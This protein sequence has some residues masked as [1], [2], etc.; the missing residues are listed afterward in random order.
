MFN[1]TETC[2]V[3]ITDIKSDH[4]IDMGV[5]QKIEKDEGELTVGGSGEDYDITAV[6]R[7]VF[8]I[9]LE[10]KNGRTKRLDY[11]TEEDRDNA[12]GEIDKIISP[13]EIK[14]CDVIRKDGSISA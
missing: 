10:Y 13:H 6:K 2:W 9:N 12:I 5:I 3:V 7:H 4:R 8:V 14:V 1:Q 11:L